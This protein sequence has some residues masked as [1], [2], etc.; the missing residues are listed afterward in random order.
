M[1]A[2]AA[3]VVAL[4]AVG[5]GTDSDDAATTTT[6]EP[7]SS[8]TTDG[9]TAES[10]TTLP[11][12]EA[13]TTTAAPTA[14]ATPADAASALFSAWKSGDSAAAGALLLAPA[15]ELD[16]LFASP[17]L[18]E[19]KNRGCDD[20]EFGTA[21]CFFGNGQGGVNVLLGGAANGWTVSSIDPFS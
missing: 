7:A 3:L 9:V 1:T 21:S 13:P 2:S 15:A 18:P 4:G 8:S 20:G 19:A 12:T 14:F 5:C 6:T 11:T 10:S 16:K 17:A